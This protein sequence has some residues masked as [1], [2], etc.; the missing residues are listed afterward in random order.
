MKTL[1]IDGHNLIPNV[2]GLHLTEMDDETRLIE[3]VQ[4]YCR[5][6]RMSAELFFDGS[7]DS[8]PNRKKSGMVHVHFVS[9]SST[10]DD[11]I[12]QFLRHLAGPKDRYKVVSS[13]HRVQNAALAAGVQTISSETFSRN[14]RAAFQSDT[15]IQ[16]TREKVPSTSEVDE[17]LA[18]FE[19]EGRKRKNQ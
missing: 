18:L 3:I 7:R 10:A 8:S 19:G 5:L 9:A 6:A 14:M 17:W 15:A 11:A 16:Q 2:P 4:E 12:I 13:D 1:I